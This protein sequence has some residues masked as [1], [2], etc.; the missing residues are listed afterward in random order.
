MSVNNFIP[1]IWTARLLAKLQKALVAGQSGVINRDY[2]G[3]IA[4]KGDTVRIGSIGAITVKPF[5][6]NTDIDAP[7]TLAD[8]VLS[9]IITE[10][11]YFNFQVDDVDARQAAVNLMDGAMSDAAY[12]M[13]DVAD[14]FILSHYVDVDPGNIVAAGLI[15]DPKAA[16]EALVNL[17]VKLDESDNPSEGRFAIVPPFFEGFML[18][19]DRFVKSG[20]D[21]AG[22]TL[23]NGQIGRAAGFNLFKSNNT[24]TSGGSSQIVGGLPMAWTYADQINKVEAFRPERRFADAVKGLHLYGAKSL[25]VLTVEVPGS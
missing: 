20:I 6:K 11:D 2:E 18:K 17:G 21:S 5:T 3:E 13:R 16:Y 19:D 23:L 7:E 15:T 14:H 4:Q 22:Q 9:L 10:A 24:P 25:A 1:T 8:D 12:R